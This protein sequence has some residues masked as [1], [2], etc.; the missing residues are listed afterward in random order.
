MTIV[1][2]ITITGCNEPAT[3]GTPRIAVT[4]SSYYCD[5]PDSI[6]F[7]AD[8]DVYI[9]DKSANTVTHCSGKSWSVSAYN[10]ELLI[11]QVSDDRIIQTDGGVWCDLNE[12]DSDMFPLRSFAVGYDNGE[13]LLYATNSFGTTAVYSL[14]DGEVV[15]EDSYDVPL[16]DGNQNCGWIIITEQDDGNVIHELSYD[17]NTYPLFNE[18]GGI[19][20]LNENNYLLHSDAGIFACDAGNETFLLRLDDSSK[21]PLPDKCDLVALYSDCIVYKT[22]GDTGTIINIAD[23]DGNV[24]NE[25]AVDDTALIVPDTYTKRLYVID[26]DKLIAQ[27]IDI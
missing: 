9:L 11:L 12:L 13:K 22:N 10:D 21:I 25:F 16:F 19:A 26:V 1:I 27:T 4:A 14:V 20:C 8:K 7:I 17:G 18:M 23:F 2:T 15:Y 5:I 24:L 6:A 3:V